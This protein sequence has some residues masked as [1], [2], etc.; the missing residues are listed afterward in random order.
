MGCLPWGELDIKYGEGNVL[1]KSKFY[2]QLRSRK[3]KMEGLFVFIETLKV[4][5]GT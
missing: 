5:L 2:I 1:I 3:L 4:T